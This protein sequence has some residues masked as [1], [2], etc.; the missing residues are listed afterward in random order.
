M[1]LISLERNVKEGQRNHGAYEVQA[2]LLWNLD[3]TKCYLRD[4][5]ETGL[6]YRGFVISRFCGKHFT[7]TLVGL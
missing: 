4:S 6:L 2:S 1:I 3:L 5:E 7:V